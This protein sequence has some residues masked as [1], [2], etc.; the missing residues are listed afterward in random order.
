LKIA[1]TAYWD[2]DKKSNHILKENSYLQLPVTAGKTY[3]MT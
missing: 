1:V 3:R 2:I